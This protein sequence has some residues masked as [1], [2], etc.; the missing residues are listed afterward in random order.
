[1]YIIFMLLHICIIYYT[2]TYT[3]CPILMYHLEYLEKYILQNF[4]I[5]QKNVSDKSFSVKF[6]HFSVKCIFQYIP[7]DTLR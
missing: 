5:L 7:G 2:C 6:Q 3:E 1:M 4:Y